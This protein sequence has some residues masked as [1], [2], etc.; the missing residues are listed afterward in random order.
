[1]ANLVRQ[2]GA[3]EALKTE[4][5][6]ALGERIKILHEVISAGLASLNEGN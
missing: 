4:S 1:L 3:N 2:R 5:K 6:E